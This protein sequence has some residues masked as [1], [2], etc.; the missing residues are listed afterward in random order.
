M[1]FSDPAH[2]GLGAIAITVLLFLSLLI[3]AIFFFTL[4]GSSSPRVQVRECQCVCV[5]VCVCNANGYIIPPPSLPPSLPPFLH[6]SH[7]PSLHPSLPTQASSLCER[8]YEA[9]VEGYEERVRW[10]GAWDLLR[11]LLIITLVVA[12]PGRTVSWLC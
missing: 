12:L 8:M 6:P 4:F 7:P 2:S 10:W 1:C 5:C 3:P 11:R 9:L